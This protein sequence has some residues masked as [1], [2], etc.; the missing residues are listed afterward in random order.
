MAIRSLQAWGRLREL[1][2]WELLLFLDFWKGSSPLLDSAM[3]QRNWS[4]T[5]SNQNLNHLVYK[6]LLSRRV[7]D[8][9]FS[10]QIISQFTE[11]DTQMVLA[12]QKSLFANGIAFI[13]FGFYTVYSSLFLALGKVRQVSFWEHVD[14]VSVLFLS[15]CCYLWYGEWTESYMPNPSQM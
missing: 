8:G 15:F 13:L 2:L 4:P 3:G 12:G 1:L 6:F 7:G 10:T 5:R 14:K 9:R 11:E